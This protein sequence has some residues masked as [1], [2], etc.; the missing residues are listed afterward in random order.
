MITKER[1]YRKTKHRIARA[2]PR[3]AAKFK[4]PLKT[5]VTDQVRC[6][7]L[8]KLRHDLRT[9]L[10]AVIGYSEMLLED[11]EDMT[12]HQDL[13]FVLRNILSTGKQS[14]ELVNTI[15]DPEKTEAGET[16]IGL[17]TF[18]ANLRQELS[19]P[20]NAI[21]SFTEI[22]LKNAEE[23]HYENGFIESSI[24]D[25]KRIHS[26][27]ENFLS[28]IRGTENLSMT[29]VGIMTPRQTPP[30]IL[31]PAGNQTAR[32]SGKHDDTVA[33]TA[34]CGDLLVVDDND[35]N[36]DLLSRHLKRQG[37]SVTVAENGREALSMIQAHTYDVVLLDI[38]MPEMDGYQVLQHL[39]SSEAWRDIPVIMISAL[40]EMNSVVRCIEM[41]AEDYLPKPFD[42]IL[43]KARIGAVLEK[44]RL[45]DKEQL[46]LRRLEGELEIGRQIQTS[47]FPDLLPQLPGWEI[48]AWFRPARQV[49]GD[50]YDAFLL[51]GGQSVGIVIADVCDKGVGAALFMGLFRSLIRAFANMHYSG[52]RMTLSEEGET[53]PD[54]DPGQM[55]E[56]QRSISSDHENALKTVI[57]LTND[58]IA[59]NHGKSNMFATLFLGVIDPETGMLTYIN[60]GH[61][62]P[63]ITGTDGV[64]K[65]LEPTGPAVGMFPGIPFDS[66]K[67]SIEPGDMLVT[68]TD[69]IT[70]AVGK[71]GGFYGKERLFSVLADPA[72]SA[73]ALLDRIETSLSDYTAGA[74]QSDD[75]TLLTVRRVPET[76]PYKRA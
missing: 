27:A 42:P 68:F 62:P 41:G 19:T 65:L 30:D 29:D 64:K 50:F 47:F 53:S 2:R 4:A 6:E 11:A 70:E 45:R 37:H 67:I 58:Y 3:R 36:R 72:A 23:L 17:E 7:I 39:K 26:A 32:T 22:L 56:R 14:F 54:A 74:E 69:G 73:G 48:A 16:K 44:K 52:S 71:D 38:M 76:P 5:E 59:L 13:I 43:L 55:T 46:Y 57:A 8:A 75:I 31:L 35:M 66:G 9:P 21:V 25:F 34:D 61:E 12:G 20:S 15:L 51:S 18:G 33:V 10:N 28:L 40:N 49:S 24:P 60:G 1:K 63:V